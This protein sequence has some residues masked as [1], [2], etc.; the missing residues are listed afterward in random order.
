M[1]KNLKTSKKV[2]V[3]P[4]KNSKYGIGK[5]VAFTES[6]PSIGSLKI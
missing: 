6:W 3:K 5:I 2:L 1:K 4:R